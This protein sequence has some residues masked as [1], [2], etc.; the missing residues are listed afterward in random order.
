MPVRWGE[1]SIWGGGGVKLGAVRPMLQYGGMEF[2]A[3]TG[4]LNRVETWTE[5]RRHD[6]W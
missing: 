3:I 2:S 1:N 6:G 4:I 5:E